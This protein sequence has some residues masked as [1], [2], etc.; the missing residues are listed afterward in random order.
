[1]KKLPFAVVV[2]DSHHGVYLGQHVVETVK[3][4]SGTVRVNDLAIVR[5]G[6]SGDNTE[7]EEAWS[8]IIDRG[9][10]VDDDGVRYFLHEDMDVWAVPIGMNWNERYQRWEWPDSVLGLKRVTAPKHWHGAVCGMDDGALSEDELAVI[11]KMRSDNAGFILSAVNYLDFSKTM[12][13]GAEFGGTE[14]YEY[15]YDTGPFDGSPYDL[16]RAAELNGAAR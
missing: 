14:I 4:D 3:F 15:V 13:Y 9:V 11:D 1:M 7:Y 2:G 6:P 5:L 16:G 8:D 10:V 12:D